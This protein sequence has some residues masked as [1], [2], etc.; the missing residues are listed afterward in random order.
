MK[1]LLISVGLVLSL[2][3]CATGQDAYYNAIAE[4]EKRQADN[5]LRADTAIANM[6]TSGG[7]EAKGMGIAY[8]IGKSAGAKQVTPI[9]APEGW[10]D[11]FLRWAA[12]LIPAVD[13]WQTS[14]RNAQVQMHISDNSVKSQESSNEMI[15]DLV[16][17]RKTPIVGGTGDVLLYGN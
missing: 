16:Q 7:P 5:E 6:A 9:P 12:V 15:V 4:R 13:R 2:T 10:D 17:G 1:R 11:K 14:K 3:A 8:F